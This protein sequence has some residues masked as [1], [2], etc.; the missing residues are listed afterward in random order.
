MEC[1]K[2][3]PTEEELSYLGEAW[4]ASIEFNKALDDLLCRS[5]KDKAFADRK[6]HKHPQHLEKTKRCKEAYQKYKGVLTMAEEKA[7]T[8]MVKYQVKKL[9]LE[10]QV[11]GADYAS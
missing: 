3:A 1:E 8:V 5:E 9:A 6:H 10:T 7:E 2:I 4:F 11:R